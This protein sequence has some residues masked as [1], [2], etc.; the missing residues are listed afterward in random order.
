MTR[1]AANPLARSG[2]TVIASARAVKQWTRGLLALGE[3]DVVSVNELSCALP[4]CP[5]KETVILVMPYRK[6]TMKISI[7]MAMREITRDDVAIALQDSGLS[8]AN[9]MAAMPSEAKPVRWDVPMLFPSSLD[10]TTD[11]EV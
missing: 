11:T 7:H 10:D 8:V 4:D 2:S 9:D 1:A 6:A 5:P 3:D